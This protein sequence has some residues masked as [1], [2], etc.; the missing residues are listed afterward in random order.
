MFS[1]AICDDQRAICSEIEKIILDYQELTLQKIQIEVFYSAE[2]LS[3]FME[4]VHKFDLIFL[5]IEM[6]GLNGLDLGRKIREEMDNQIT[7][8]VYVSG[9]VEFVKNE[10][11]GTL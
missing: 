5:D 4:H 8:I 9:K 11:S 7:Q 1:I 10:F 3:T 6:E 2:K